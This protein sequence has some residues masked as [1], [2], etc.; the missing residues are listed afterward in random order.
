MTRNNVFEKLVGPMTIGML[1]KAH[2]VTHDLTGE[3][4]A[5][6]LKLTKGELLKLESGKERL[7]LKDT[8]K[9]AKKLEEFEDFWAL[10]WFQEEARNAGLDFHKYLKNHLD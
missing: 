1:L 10:I 5:K 2:Q 6:K 8:L 9:I 3:Q 7:A 4:L